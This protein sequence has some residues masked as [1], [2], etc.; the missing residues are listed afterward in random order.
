[1]IT[2]TSPAL[3]RR[4]VEYLNPQGFCVDPCRGRGAF[5]DALDPENRD[6][7]E[8]REG[9][10]FLT[11]EFDRHIDWCITNPP[12]SD[13]YADIAARAFTIADNVAFL[14]KL[15]VAINTYARH[16][17]WCEA[18]HGLRQVTI[19]PWADAGFVNEDG[20]VKIAEGFVL[21]LVWWHAVTR[22]MSSG[23]I[24]RPK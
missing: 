17:A 8:I 22:A 5:Y 18:G 23:P 19:I 20:T 12:F 14:V 7:C 2:S 10:D 3:P 11:W 1:M 16:R 15:D 13:A 4:I 24:G 9:R 21:A 6:W